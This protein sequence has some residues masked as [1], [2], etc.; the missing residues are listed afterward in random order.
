MK[1]SVEVLYFADLKDITDKQ[2]EEIS[3]SEFSIRELK[4]TIFEKYP[5]LKNQ[6]WSTKKENFK[7]NIS[8]V[9]NDQK[10]SKKYVLNYKL[11]KGDKIAFL[12]PISGG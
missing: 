4:D 10:I 11:H 9:I 2:K 3:L 6:L 1:M 7:P 12:L 8:I 5:E